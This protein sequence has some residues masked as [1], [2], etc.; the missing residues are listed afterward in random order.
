MRVLKVLVVGMGI[1]IVVATVVLVTIIIQRGMHLGQSG[2]TAEKTPP[3]S[4]TAA[5]VP[6]GSAPVTRSLA[7]PAGARV[8]ETRLSGDWLLLRAILADGAEAIFVFDS[9][10]GHLV[11]RYDVGHKAAP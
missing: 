1:V 8:Q 2:T 3:G 6:P 11:A 7:L 9:R 4:A 5:S 10:S